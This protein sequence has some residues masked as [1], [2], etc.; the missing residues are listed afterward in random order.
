MNR[1]LH[2]SHKNNKRSVP[3]NAQAEA[4]FKKVKQDL[5]IATLLSNSSA[6]AEILLITD[7][8][9]S[10]M[11]AAFE[12]LL[13]IWKPLAFFLQKFASTK[14]LLQY[15]WWITYSYLESRKYLRYF[16]AGRV[17]RIVTEHKPLT[18][19]FSQRV[20]KESHR[21]RWQLS[22]IS[23]FSTCIEQ[24]SDMNNVVADTLFRDESNVFHNK[25]QID[26]LA[27]PHNSDFSNLLSTE[28]RNFSTIYPRIS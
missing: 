19:A 20:D 16:I 3:W 21:H 10:G 14:A 1:F 2:E 28:W 4:A 5:S 15:K 17:F 24:L 22:F 7:P 26:E 11:G 6:D 9:V 18:F 23:Q 27:R 13:D 25:A 8:S 12:Q